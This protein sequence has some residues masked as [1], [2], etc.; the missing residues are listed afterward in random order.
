MIAPSN[1]GPYYAKSAPRE[2]TKEELKV[3]VKQFGE[4]ALRFKKA[5][6]DG[7]EIQAAHAHGLLGGFL[8]P[9]YNKRTDE[10]GGDIHGRLRL[11]LEVIEEVRKQCGRDFIIDVRISGDEYSD[12]GLTL[13][14]MIYVSKQLEKATVD[15]FMFLEE[16]PLKKEVQCQ[17]VEQ[18]RHHINMQVKKLKNMYLF[19]WQQF[20]VSTNLG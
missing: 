19:Q 13:N 1:V 6:G 7:V 20:R 17:Q 2:V 16:I 10:Y 5:G 18:L 4:A 12:G 11:T 9:L 15:L 3:I 14:D 8:T